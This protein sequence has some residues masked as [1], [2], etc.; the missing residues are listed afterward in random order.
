MRIDPT[1]ARELDRALLAEIGAG[2]LYGRLA[3]AVRDDE[4]ARVL[5][6]LELDQVEQL[7]NVRAVV[8]ELGARPRAHGR[9]RRWLARA[10]A[11]LRPVLGQRLVLRICA[12]AERTRAVGYAQLAQHFAS[13]GRR[14]LAER[15][16]QAASVAS[17]H[18]D[19]LD[20][21]VAHGRA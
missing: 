2:E 18:G 3:S 7:S 21:W 11:A 6:G 4:L 13:S 10:L 5:A 1:L 14:S 12:D 8:E 19:A 15:C 9:R 17:R 20:A 16:R